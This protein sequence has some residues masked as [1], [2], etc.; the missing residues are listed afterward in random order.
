MSNSVEMSNNPTREKYRAYIETVLKGLVDYPEQLTVSLTE[1]EKNYIITVALP[2]SNV[3]Q[4]IGTGGRLL[5]ALQTLFW[6]AS[7]ALTDQVKGNIIEHVQID[8]D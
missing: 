3:G 5:T 2:E 6:A 8:V 1:A 4:I 7:G